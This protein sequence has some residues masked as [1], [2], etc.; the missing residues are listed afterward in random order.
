MGSKRNTLRDKAEKLLSARPKKEPP[1][2]SAS[3]T[4]ELEVHQIEL[5]MQNEELRA[6]QLEIEKS[7]E[8]YFDLYDLAPVGYLTLNE[9][10]LITELNLTAAGFLGVERESLINKPFSRFIDPDF[11]DKFYSSQSRGVQVLHEADLRTWAQEA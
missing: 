8:K 1:L 5:E 4:H 2:N 11:Q 7:R 10:G 6:S 9:K 3:L